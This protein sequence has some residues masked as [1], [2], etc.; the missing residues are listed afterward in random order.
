LVAIHEYLSTIG[1]EKS[2]MDEQGMRIS[3]LLINEIVKLKKDEIW[4]YYEIIEKH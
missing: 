2:N 4:P 1:A 3:K